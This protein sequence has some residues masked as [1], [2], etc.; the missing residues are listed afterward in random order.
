MSNEF[1]C[2]CCNGRL[3]LPLALCMVAATPP[4]GPCRR[5]PSI[6]ISDASA[7]CHKTRPTASPSLDYQ[8]IKAAQPHS[9]LHTDRVCCHCVC[10]CSLVL[11]LW[12]TLCRDDFLVSSFTWGGGATTVLEWVPCSVFISLLLSAPSLSPPPLPPSASVHGLRAP[13]ARS[14][15]FPIGTSV[16][17][18]VG[19]QGG[20][21]IHPH[22]HH[23]GGIV[24]FPA[25]H[26][27]EELVVS[28]SC[29]AD[30]GKE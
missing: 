12:P 11:E 27:G 5:G 22:F 15:E 2:C 26:G 3:C 23:A 17:T 6:A 25:V 7:A 19:D 14:L 20:R 28:A 13:A 16:T 8:L 1:L 18:M 24:G 21:L 4:P 9:T 30:G 10:G 29:G